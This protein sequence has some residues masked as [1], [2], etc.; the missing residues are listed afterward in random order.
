MVC[1]TTPVAPD[2]WFAACVA[3]RVIGTVGAV[4]YGKVAL[5]GFMTVH[6]DLQRQGIGRMLMEHVLAWL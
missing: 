6:P 3:G 5:V 4:S 2:G 1:G